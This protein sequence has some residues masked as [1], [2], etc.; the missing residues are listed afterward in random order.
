MNK[1][2]SLAFLQSCI[3]SINAATTEEIAWF[4]ES[5]ALNCADFTISS[6]FEF[7]PPVDIVGCL[8]EAN[9]VMHMKISDAEC[10]VDIL[11]NQ[12]NYNLRGT[13]ANN[14]Q[15]DENLPYAA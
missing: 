1:K 13:C 6:I 14:E 11:E 9:E 12:W 5:Y 3:D 2:E 7:I 10:V 4:Q 8:Y 15:S